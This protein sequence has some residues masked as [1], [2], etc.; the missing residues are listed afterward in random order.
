MRMSRSFVAPVALA[1]ALALV[2]ATA[3]TAAA[4]TTVFVT[5]LTGEAEV[6]LG[7]LD[8]SG[9]AVVR[10]DA[11]TGKV[12]WNYKVRDVAPIMAA[13]IHIAPAGVPGPVVVPFAGADATSGVSVGCTMADPA[14]VSAIVNT[15]SAYYVNVH[16]ADFPAGALRGQLG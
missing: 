11:D 10:L 13:H 16:N 5:N 15:P 6:P 3:G 1:A 7:D 9:V 4:S 2:V 12:C 8:G 14:L